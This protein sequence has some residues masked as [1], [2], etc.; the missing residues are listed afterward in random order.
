ME[1]MVPE[2]TIHEFSTGVDGIGSAKTAGYVHIPIYVDCMSRVGGKTGKV[3][4]NLEIH[5]A[6]GLSVDL[7]VGMDAIHAYG[8]DTIV[9]RS[10]ALFTVNKCEMAFLH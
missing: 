9:S 7:I 10:M 1:R 5:L 4:P 6:D 8:I 2:A 3:E